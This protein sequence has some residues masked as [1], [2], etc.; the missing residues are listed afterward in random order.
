MALNCAC[1]VK[2][3]FTLWVV[4]VDFQH[5]I[6]GKMSHGW[7]SKSMLMK[8]GPWC[9]SCNSYAGD[10]I[11]YPPP[12]SN[13]CTLYSKHKEYNGAMS[14]GWCVQGGGHTHI[15]RIKIYL[16]TAMSINLLFSLRWSVHWIC[17]VTIFRPF[18]LLLGFFISQN[19][20]TGTN[21]A[22]P[23]KSCQ[24]DG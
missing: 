23:K 6:S 12:V 8:N 16:C 19:K 14:L 24:T 18:Y 7:L 5:G 1:I 22:Q 21:R 9:K 3:Q 15:W 17:S 4:P 20:Y 2:C 13:R 10:P 11:L